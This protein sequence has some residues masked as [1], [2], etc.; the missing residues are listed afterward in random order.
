MAEVLRLN[1]ADQRIGYSGYWTTIPNPGVGQNEAYTYTV[2]LGA[3]L[4]FL[5]R[6]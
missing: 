4:F 5:F 3:N 1:T 2:T 6:G